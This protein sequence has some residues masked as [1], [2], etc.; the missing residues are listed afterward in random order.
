MGTGKQISLNF[1]YK[2][3][4]KPLRQSQ[5]PGY[6]ADLTKEKKEKKLGSFCFDILA[7]ARLK[8]SEEASGML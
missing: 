8:C 2:P 6:Q 5:A 4:L 1:G 3:E 7:L